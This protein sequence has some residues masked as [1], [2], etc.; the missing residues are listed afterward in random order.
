MA[1]NKTFSQTVLNKIN[2]A[3]LLAI[4]V[5][6]L[7]ELEAPSRLFL[8]KLSDFLTAAKTL[9]A[10]AVF[11]EA[12]FLEEDEFTYQA[13]TCYDPDLEELLPALEHEADE[14]AESE[15]EPEY[16]AIWVDAEDLDGFDL[17]MVDNRLAKYRDRIGQECGL[18]LA[19]PGI[20]R[21]ELEVYNEWYQKFAEIADKATERIESDPGAVL[22][23]FQK[24][25]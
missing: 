2:N 15:A 20:D 25:K 22:E 5:N 9:E 6:V 7:N 14:N 16:S 10:K 21:L 18:R 3:G 19:L 4:P 8:G 11:V 12:L 17:T 1:S 13:E 23:K 24:R